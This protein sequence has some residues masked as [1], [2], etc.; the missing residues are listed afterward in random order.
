M[1]P[2][3]R[4]PMRARDWLKQEYAALMAAPDPPAAIEKRLHDKM[5]E[6]RQR[7]KVDKALTVAGIHTLLYSK[8]GHKSPKQGHKLPKQG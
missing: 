6:A 8:L 7:N 1:I 2:V 4:V 5:V 3:D